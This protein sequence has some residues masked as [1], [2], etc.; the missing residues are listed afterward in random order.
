M[1]M[2]LEEVKAIF[3]KQLY[4]AKDFHTDIT[5]FSGTT[6]GTILKIRGHYF[7]FYYSGEC[8]E[9]CQNHFGGV[10]FNLKSGG[11]LTLYVMLMDV[12]SEQNGCSLIYCS[13]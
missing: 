7:G 9:W 6:P 12:K 13:S 1:M 10:A 4:V 5:E 8:G 3:K 2:K 11:T